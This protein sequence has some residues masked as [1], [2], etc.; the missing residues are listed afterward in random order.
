MLW[1]G[2]YSFIDI[3]DRPDRMVCTV[4][5]CWHQWT[6]KSSQDY[7]VTGGYVKWIPPCYRSEHSIGPAADIGDAVGKKMTQSIVTNGT[8][9]G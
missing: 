4:H 2:V 5:D 7:R 9:Q 3:A 6:S 8:L 1:E